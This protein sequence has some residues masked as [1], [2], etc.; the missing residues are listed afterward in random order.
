MEYRGFGHERGLLL[1]QDKTTTI[2][3]HTNLV[4]ADLARSN[5]GEAY[6]ARLR[7]AVLRAEFLVVR[8]ILVLH[9]PLDAHHLQVD[10]CMP[11][12]ARMLMIVCVVRH[13]CRSTEPSP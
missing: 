4:L 13:L 6:F 7:A 9:T 10:C 11:R 8:N 1:T 12:V 2:E 3:R 5:S